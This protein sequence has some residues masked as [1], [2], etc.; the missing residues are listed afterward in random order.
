MVTLI[1]I[2]KDGN[3]LPPLVLAVGLQGVKMDVSGYYGW[4]LTIA[5]I[6]ES[7]ANLQNSVYEEPSNQKMK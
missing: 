1:S 5:G 7:S 2:I 6:R 4:R 3:T